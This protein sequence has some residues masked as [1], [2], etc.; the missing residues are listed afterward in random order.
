MI[1]K[2]EKPHRM[3]THQKSYEIMSL[4]EFGKGN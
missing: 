4:P 3:K 1:A 2:D